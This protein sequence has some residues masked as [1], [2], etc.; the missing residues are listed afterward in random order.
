[1]FNYAFIDANQADAAYCRWVAVSQDNVYIIRKKRGSGC[2]CSCQDIGETR[3]LIPIANI[4][5]VMITEP[6]G[7]AVCCFINNVLTT[8]RIQAAASH[9]GTEYEKWDYDPESDRDYLMGLQDPKRFRDVVMGLKKGRYV[10][11]TGGTSAFTPVADSLS[12][13]IQGI[14]G[15]PSSTSASPEMLNEL[16]GIRQL[17]SQ[18]MELRKTEVELMRSMDEKLSLLPKAVNAV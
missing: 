10:A 5:D 8:V 7:T 11:K 12:G 13:V 14:E 4:Q 2:R 1:M 9:G 6:A 15:S 17:L 3:K 18:D 16:R